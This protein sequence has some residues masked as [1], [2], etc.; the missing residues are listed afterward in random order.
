MDKKKIK[1]KN[2]NN[3][4]CLIFLSPILDSMNLCAFPKPC[5][6]VLNIRAPSPS[7]TELYILVLSVQSTISRWMLKSYCCCCPDS[8][9]KNNS[10]QIPI[11]SSLRGKCNSSEDGSWLVLWDKPGF[12]PRLLLL[13][14]RSQNPRP[15]LH[16]VTMEWAEEGI[17]GPLQGWCL[18]SRIYPLFHP[19]GHGGYFW[20]CSCHL[21]Q[22]PMSVRQLPS[23]LRRVP[24]AHE[25][26]QLLDLGKGKLS[27]GTAQSG[28][29]FCAL[30]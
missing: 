23:P 20:P 24:S 13:G 12:Y 19:A 2:P 27:Q 6:C 8:C 21:L 26:L 18:E 29:F 4:K 16:V 5:M 30:T 1:F 22:Y 9:C 15:G 7:D 25:S 17:S 14:L 28:N 11:S 3:T 10:H